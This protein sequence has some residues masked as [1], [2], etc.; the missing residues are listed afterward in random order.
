[1]KQILFWYFRFYKIKQNSKTFSCR[2]KHNSLNFPNKSA[3]CASVDSQ[4]ILF[5]LSDYSNLCPIKYAISSFRN[6]YIRTRILPRDNHLT[7]IY[8]EIKWC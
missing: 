8:E 6:S 3:R 5:N 4:V 1:M 7:F 2:A